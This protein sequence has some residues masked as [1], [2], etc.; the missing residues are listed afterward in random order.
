M[1]L[2]DLLPPGDLWTVEEGSTLRGMLEAIDTEFTRVR[3]RGAALIEE[4]DPRTATETIAEWER[5]VGLPDER[6][7]A[8]SAVLGERRSAVVQKLVARGGQSLGFFTDLFAACGWRFEAYTRYS[9]L[10]AGFRCGTAATGSDARAYGPEYV[11]TAHFVDVAQNLY[12]GA[13]TPIS[14]ADLERVI[15]HACHA[16]ITVM[17]TYL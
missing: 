5:A 12:A 2:I 11:Y 9:V 4:S 3:S 7:T 17:F 14:A 15:R 16:H 13:P 1:P 8:I 6:V 10:R